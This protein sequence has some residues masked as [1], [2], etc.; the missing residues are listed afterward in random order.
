MSSTAEKLVYLQNGVFK[1]KEMATGLQYYH[2]GAFK[3]FPLPSGNGTFVLS[4]YNNDFTWVD[5]GVVLPE[6]PEEFTTL[7][8]S[9][10]K[11]SNSQAITIATRGTIPYFVNNS[12]FGGLDLPGSGK[13][14]LNIEDD[15]EPSFSTFS[16]ST[17]STELGFGNT[18]NKYAIVNWN[19][20]ISSHTNLF[21]PSNSG[22]YILKAT[23]AG[24]FGNT[25]EF[26]ELNAVGLFHDTLDIQ[27]TNLCLIA[28]KG[29]SAFGVD[30]PAM[31]SSSGYF[32]FKNEKNTEL[33]TTSILNS[34]VIYQ[35]ILGCTNT[36]RC[37]VY[38]DGSSV[39]KLTVPTTAGSYVLNVSSN[40]L[41][42]TTPPAKLS[43]TFTYTWPD[44]G[45][46]VVS[47][48]LGS[49]NSNLTEELMLSSNIKYLVTIDLNLKCGDYE[50]AFVGFT[51]TPT[52][53]ITTVQSTL[54][55]ATLDSP[56]PSMNVSGTSLVTPTKDGALTLVVTRSGD[57]TISHTYSHFQ[58]TI[59]EL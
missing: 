5:A 46:S 10:F 57:T 26:S 38:N 29:N 59:V 45:H 37:L 58:V 23:D 20:T 32:V 42:F 47:E 44:S 50:Q 6:Q 43:K 54:L 14:L 21:L 25:Y 9:Y 34:T 1:R 15:G 33:P 19:S 36:E 40:G 55:K 13:Y 35:D 24:A 7:D 8:N 48:Y 18:S 11:D 17:I 3:T 53:V 39:S 28:Y 31:N 12:T 27:S 30:V 52:L 49:D 51:S 2:N 4:N 22:T 41:S 16:K 56:L